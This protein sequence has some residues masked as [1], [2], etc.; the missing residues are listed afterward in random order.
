MA[1]SDNLYAE[2]DSL[3]AE[4]RKGGATR[5]ADTLHHRLHTVTWTTRDELLEELQ[6][7]LGTALE[8]HTTTLSSIL[9]GQVNTLLTSISRNL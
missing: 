3:I 6:S 4:L 7:V 5:L 9:R 8:S 1:T 2:V